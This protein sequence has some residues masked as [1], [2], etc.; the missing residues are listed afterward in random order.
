LNLSKLTCL[1]IQNCFNL[2]EFLQDL[3]EA[4]LGIPKD[5]LKTLV[6]EQ[7]NKEALEQR[8]SG[9]L[10]AIGDLDYLHI[11]VPTAKRIDVACLNKHR[12]LRCFVMDPLNAWDNELHIFP[13]PQTHIYGAH[14]YDEKEL[15]LLAKRCPNLEEL[16]TSLPMMSFDNWEHTKPFVW[17][18]A[19]NRIAREALLVKALVSTDLSVQELLLNRF[20]EAIARF[21]KLRVLRLVHRPIELPEEDEDNARAEDLSRERQWC[22]QQLAEQILQLLHKLYSPVQ[23]L[24]F[25]PT[26]TDSVGSPDDNGHEWPHYYYL[27][28]ESTTVLPRDRKISKVVAVPV[29]KDDIRD[30]IGPL[31]ILSEH[32]A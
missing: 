15:S 9:L 24:A 8:V 4:Y 20:K 10:D 21:P 12:A 2:P 19:G 26:I 5:S 32:C 11:S 28:G 30:Y 6:I 14:M 31:R 1:T 3:R 22:H 18:P 27:R 23:L 17:S 16:G 7:N 13:H 29:R 25:S